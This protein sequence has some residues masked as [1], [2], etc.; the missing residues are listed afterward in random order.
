MLAGGAL[1]RISKV[2][3]ESGPNLNKYDLAASGKMSRL[4]ENDR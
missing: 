2:F 1:A 4:W 3:L